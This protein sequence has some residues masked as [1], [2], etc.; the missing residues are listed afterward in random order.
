[1]RAFGSRGAAGDACGGGLK[2]A[3]DAADAAAEALASSAAVEGRMPTT[4]DATK[5]AGDCVCGE[6][7]EGR[8]EADETR[9]SE[10]CGDEKGEALAL[11]SAV[12][13]ANAGERSV[14]GDPRDEEE[15]D[16]DKGRSDGAA[17]TGR[18]KEVE[19]PAPPPPGDDRWI[20]LGA[21]RMGEA[22]ARLGRL[23]P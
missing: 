22:P 13:V 19:K 2:R 21:T 10:A 7:D 8:R 4:A 15:E 23:A 5:L 17:D 18:I 12:L 11:A 20:G 6:P 3:A 1:V 9:R 16:D 14:G